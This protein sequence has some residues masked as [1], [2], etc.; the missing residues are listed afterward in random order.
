MA[1]LTPSLFPHDLSLRANREAEARVFVALEQA[2]DDTWQVFYDRRV[3]GARRPIDFI[4]VHPARKVLA[5]EV[6]GGLVHHT[7]KGFRQVVRSNG[8]RKRVAPFIQTQQAWTEL[9]R[10]AG[11]SAS[12]PQVHIAACF[13]LMSRSAF[14]WP[15]P[16]RHLFLRED[17]SDPN[18]LLAKL[19]L[20]L[21]P[22]ADFDPAF[23]SRLVASLSLD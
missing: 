2:L 19:E 4:V 12:S 18:M 21:G 3:K 23:N 15:D 14:P 11:L 6:K 9:L 7:R 17:L 1:L 20:V 10:C 22:D 8:Q 5:L 16:G 13:P